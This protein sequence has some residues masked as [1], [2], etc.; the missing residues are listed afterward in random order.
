MVVAGELEMGSQGPMVRHPRGR[1]VGVNFC[2]SPDE[3]VV[4]NASSGLASLSL[5]CTS[6]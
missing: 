3:N 1:G 4:E 5:T 6:L 2:S